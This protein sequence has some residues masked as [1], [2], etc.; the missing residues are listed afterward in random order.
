MLRR[1]TMAALIA[2]CSSF[3]AGASDTT[4]DSGDE[5]CGYDLVIVAGSQ[6]PVRVEREQ[7]SHIPVSENVVAW[8]C[9]Q[10]GD[11]ESEHTECPEQT[12]V[13]VIQRHH[14]GDDRFLYACI[15]RR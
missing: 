15:L 14:R 3:S 9:Q 11:V 8:T 12:N 10:G 1:F 5:T 4:L 7:T 2:A 13:F 6:G